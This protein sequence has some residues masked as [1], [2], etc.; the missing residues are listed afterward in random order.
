MTTGKQETEKIVVKSIDEHE[1]DDDHVYVF[2]T[3]TGVVVD[4]GKADDG[5][6]AV[7]LEEDQSEFS[8]EGA[9]SHSMKYSSLYR[10]ANSEPAVNY[11]LN[12]RSE[13]LVAYGYSFNYPSA[14]K[15]TSATLPRQAPVEQWEEWARYVNLDHVL[16]QAAH[17]LLLTGNVWIEKIYDTSGFNKGG[18]G[19]RK[20]RVLSPDTMHNVVDEH[21]TIQ[22]F[23]QTMHNTDRRILTP[24]DARKIM[25]NTD[26]SIKIDRHRIVYM[27]YNAYYDNTVYG[28]GAV[29]PL[30]RYAKSKLGVQKR[31]LRIIENH[32]TSFTLFRYGSKEHMVMGAKAEKFMEQLK[33]RGAYPKYV[34]LPWYFEVEPVQTEGNLS[35]IAE[36]MQY[37]RDEELTGIGLPPVLTGKGGSSEGAQ[38][39]LE[40]L[41]RQTKYLQNVMGNELRR[42]L[43]PEVVFGDPAKSNRVNTDPSMYPYLSPIVYSTLIPELRWNSIESIADMRLRHDVYAKHGLMSVQEIRKEVGYSG[44]VARSSLPPLVQQGFEAIEV[45]REAQRL[46]QQQQQQDVGKK[47]KKQCVVGETFKNACWSSPAHE[48]HQ[49][50]LHRHQGVRG[51]TCWGGGAQARRHHSQRP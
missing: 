42:Q 7:L 44:N 22:F 17:S 24:E 45:Q 33:K 48:D 32:A 9:I 1:F 13:I 12:L 2:S 31:A 15:S 18:W 8:E 21:G 39:Q 5:V 27:N 23:L 25:K 19:V 6:A 26:N 34:V 35:S 14:R 49:D 40:I 46:Q 4:L 3:A 47:K 50:L 37:F 16:R 11:G 28:W 43:F 41:V 10:L 51:R 29:V 30:L 20:L 36:Y 38:I